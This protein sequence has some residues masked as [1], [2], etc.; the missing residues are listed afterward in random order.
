MI[1]S[2]SKKQGMIVELRINDGVRF[3]FEYEGD[4]KELFE[5]I[6]D[7]FEDYRKVMEHRYPYESIFKKIRRRIARVFPARS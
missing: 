5:R 7:T 3:T 1:S 2:L 4:L 6:D